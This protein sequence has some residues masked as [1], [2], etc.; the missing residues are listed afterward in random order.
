[1][2]RVIKQ[3]DKNHF[4]QR[5]NATVL[6]FIIVLNNFLVLSTE[7][8]NET[9]INNK[10]KTQITIICI[11]ILM[12]VNSYVNAQDRVFTHTYQTNVIPFGAKEVEYWTTL[13]SGRKE[14][15]NAF[16]QRF[17]FELGVGKKI[18]T[19]F[20]FNLSNENAAAENGITSSVVTGFSNEWKFKITDPVANKIGS[21]LYAE[22]GFNGQEIE[23]EGKL[24][25]D[26]KFGNNLVAFNGAVE[27]EIKYDVV[28][29]VTQSEHESPFELNFAYMHLIGK[30]FGVGLEARNHNEVSPDKGWENSVWYAGP[31]IHFGGNSWLINL[32]VQ[33][34]LFNAR[35]EDG[36]T[37][38]L[39]LTAH[40]K[41][42]TRLIVSF[43]F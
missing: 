38:N 25:L 1:M 30:N 8:F 2:I 36:S 19:A 29:S 33:P 23:L 7:F 14:F 12:C 31:S 22:V 32:N 26:K 18:Q 27:Y 15:Y 10:M 41:V 11:S 13:R 40:E 4:H 20:Y 39:E 43:D 37:E 35:K 21:A 5:R 34:Q 3:S 16:D 42:E 6:Q 28:N 24:I 17:E 9:L